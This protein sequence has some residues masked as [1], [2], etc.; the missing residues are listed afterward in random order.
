MAL[1][2]FFVIASGMIGLVDQGSYSTLSS[3]IKDVGPAIVGGEV[4]Q[5]MSTAAIVGMTVTGGLSGSLSEVQQIY[6]VLLILITWLSV[7]WILRYFTANG[8]MPKIRDALYSSGAPLV[9]TLVIFVIAAIQALPAV[10]GMILYS[11]AQASGLLLDGAGAMVVAVALGLLLL[12]SLYWVSSTFLAAVIVTIPGT[13][14]MSALRAAGDIALGRRLPLIVRVVWLALFLFGIWVILLVPVVLLGDVKWLAS[15]PVV[16]VF[17]QALS[18]FTTL[19]V[20]TYIYRLY[21]RM[22]D[23]DSN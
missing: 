17:V 1:V 7:V 20:S 13:Y 18:G 14:P 3:A 16:P 22:I 6:L 19:F 15:I 5:F 2:L 4:D 8:R 23:E 9:S 10:I 11:A 21:R 12:L